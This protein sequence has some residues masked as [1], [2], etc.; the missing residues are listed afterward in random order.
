MCLRGGGVESFKHTYTKVV[1]GYSYEV[2]ESEGGGWKIDQIRSRERINTH[3]L[4]R[5]VFLLYFSFLPLFF[6]STAYMKCMVNGVF[7]EVLRRTA[8]SYYF[9]QKIK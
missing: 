3:G 9:S 8:I 7:Y 4:Q 2:K 5:R 6:R 1:L